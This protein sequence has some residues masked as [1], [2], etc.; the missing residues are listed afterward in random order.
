LADH[1]DHAEL[2]EIEHV[3]RR[4]G[5]PGEPDRAE[6]QHPGKRWGHAPVEGLLVVHRCFSL[7]IA[8]EPPA[9]YFR[10]IRSD[11][12]ILRSVGGGGE[13]GS[14]CREE[15]EREKETAECSPS[16][17]RAGRGYPSTPI[18]T[19]DALITA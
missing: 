13:R 10:Y 19:L 12:A 14:V 17:R 11:T 6:Q 5:R 9:R 16:Q 4:R 7:R 1:G 8:G 18:I 15:I 2:A 3:F